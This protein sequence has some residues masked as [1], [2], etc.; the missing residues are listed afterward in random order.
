[1]RANFDDGFAAFAG[2]V[3]QTYFMAHVGLTAVTFIFVATAAAF[4]IAS[5]GHLKQAKSARE[6]AFAAKRTAQDLAVEV[7]HLTAQVER[8]LATAQTRGEPAARPA[9]LAG[10]DVMGANPIRVGA[11]RD[12]D[13][14]DV[15][16][17]GAETVSGRTEPKDDAA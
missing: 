8:A 14:A 15:E 13:E 9:K 1:V 17:I 16:I 11:A 10:G 4:S 5:L 3:M 2:D 7:R 12:T 6:E